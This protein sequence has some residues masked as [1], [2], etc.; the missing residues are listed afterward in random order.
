MLDPLIAVVGA[1]TVGWSG[2]SGCC[3]ARMVTGAEGLLN[4]TEFLAST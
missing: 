1:I 3:A 4:P 2:T